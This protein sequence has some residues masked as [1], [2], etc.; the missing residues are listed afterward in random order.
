MDQNHVDQAYAEELF[1]WI[2]KGPDEEQ[3]KQK[4]QELANAFDKDAKTV[5]E[6]V[7]SVA[8]KE[9]LYPQEPSFLVPEDAAPTWTNCIGEQ[10]CVPLQYKYPASLSDLVNI[11]HDAASQNPKVPVRAIGSGHSFSDITDSQGAILVD[12]SRN[13]KQVLT[14]DP[15]ILHPGADAPNTIRAQCGIKVAALNQELDARNLGLINMG[16]YD[17]QTISGA[18]STGTHGSG[19]N[20]GPMADFLL[21][22]V[23]VTESGKVYQIEPSPDLAITNPAKFPGHLPEAPDIPVELKQDNTWFNAAKVAMGCLGLIYSYALRVQPAFSI[24]EVRSM[25]TWEDVKPHLSSFLDGIDHFE[26]MINPYAD[27][28]NKHKCVKVERTRKPLTAPRGYRLC[29]PWQWVEDQGV[30]HSQAM[31]TLLNFAH[32][33]WFTRFIINQALGFL[34]DMD[35]PYVDVSHKVLTLGVENTAKAWA[36]EMHF[37]GEK[38]CVGTIDSVLAAFERL[39]EEQ[40]YF[41]GGPLGIRFVK[42]SDALIAPQAGRFTCTVECDMLYGINHARKLLGEIKRAICDQSSLPGNDSIRVHWGLDWG[43]TTAEDVRK[44]YPDLGKWQAVYQEVNP[45]GMFDN[46]FTKRLRLRE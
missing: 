43:Y 21:S 18:L 3:R 14:V 36:L 42:A 33:L 2:Y 25:T 22:I 8:T 26:L 10:P 40:G 28:D 19:K 11:V 32:S 17:G 13:L 27:D 35:P 30:H 37:N 16:A 23:L 34:P 20:F 31:V 1:L 12:P 38:D 45:G 7:H 6:A 5:L 9:N 4:L 39:W 41:I 44:W 29:G 24:S 46:E 15:S